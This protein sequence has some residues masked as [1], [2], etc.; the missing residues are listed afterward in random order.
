MGW[1]SEYSGPGYY[2]RKDTEVSMAKR[3]YSRI[4][5]PPMLIWLAEAS[6][7][8]SKQIKQATQAALN[9]K[10]SFPSQ[11]SAIR[12][13]IPWEDVEAKLKA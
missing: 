4:N 11:C 12:Q 7:I 3:V 10:K 1:L 6:G 8:Q 2:N 13:I 5:C 9:A